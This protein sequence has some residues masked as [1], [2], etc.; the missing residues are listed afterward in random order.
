MLRPVATRAL[1]LLLILCALA[2]CGD[3]GPS[4]EQ[5]I[6]DTLSGFERAAAGH[7]YATLCDRILAPK[8][9]SSLEQ[10]GLPCETA[11]QK[12][13]EGLRDPR[14][15]VGTVTVN[16][17]AATAQVRSSAAGQSPSEDTV[18]LV[19]VGDG[20]RIASLGGTGAAP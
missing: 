6:R 20:W 10:I 14:L 1:P 19:R 4:D 7:D 12:G 5:R 11:L 15:S 2:G 9:I 17:D 18:D 13:F 8:L 3:A 16:G